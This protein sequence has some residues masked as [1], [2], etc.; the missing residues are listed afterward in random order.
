MHYLVEDDVE[1]VVDVGN[2]DG[3]RAGGFIGLGCSCKQCIKQKIAPKCLRQ[4]DDRA[5]EYLGVYM[6]LLNGSSMPS[7]RKRMAD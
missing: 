5:G 4:V 6:Q 7:R 2:D 1:T 3:G